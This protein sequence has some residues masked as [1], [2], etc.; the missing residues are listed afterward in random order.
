MPKEY[1]FYDENQA[2]LYLTGCL[3]MYQGRPAF[4][5]EVG[6]GRARI[7]STLYGI[8][9]SVSIDSLDLSCIELGYVNFNK[10][11][12]RDSR[13][14]TSVFNGQGYALSVC[15]LPTRMAKIGLHESNMGINYLPCQG[16]PVDG[17]SARHV[18]ESHQLA[19]AIVKEFPSP[20]EATKLLDT[21]LSVAISTYFAVDAGSKNV[22]HLFYQNDPVGEYV[23][24][25]VKLFS[26]TSFLKEKLEHQGISHVD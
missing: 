1:K 9:T 26:H 6:N 7:T 2:S 23:N 18:L 13:G 16:G 17:I 11:N 10:Y 15:R 8:K 5:T 24:G 22:Y 25:G 12:G 4:V 3:V 20:K 19:K 14:T 21:C